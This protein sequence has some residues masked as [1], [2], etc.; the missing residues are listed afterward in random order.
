MRRLARHLFT[1]C[2]AL[3]LVLCVAVCVLWVRSYS[4]TARGVLVLGGC[5]FELRQ[6]R[7]SVR[8]WWI[9]DDWGMPTFAR[10]FEIMQT[11]HGTRFYEDEHGNPVRADGAWDR[12]WRSMLL[13]G[14]HTRQ[15]G[16]M[17][18]WWGEFQTDAAHP[19]AVLQMHHGLLAG[20]C[21][22]PM[23]LAAARVLRR[24][25]RSTLGLCLQC[26]YDLRASPGRCPECGAAAT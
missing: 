14:S 12:D 11:R 20:L 13:P 16:G 9:A 22:T 18:V 4:A 15:M 2:S 1:L 21:A 3:S 24:R 19:S 25:R 17:A 26:G 7:G 10:S 23:L 8:V 6:Y 5:T